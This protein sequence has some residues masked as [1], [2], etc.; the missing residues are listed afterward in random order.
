VR[1]GALAGELLQELGREHRRALPQIA[2]VLDVG[3]GRVDVAAVA[4]MHR[5][6][7]GVIPARLSGGNDLVPPPVVVGEDARVEVA[8]GELHRAGQRGEVE[9]VRRAVLTGVPE[10]VG[11]D[12]PA[13]RVGVRDLDRLAVRRRED[14]AGPVGVAAGHVLAGRD[15]R[16]D[17]D[18]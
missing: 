14:V 10:R 8:E 4:R 6:R 18:R 3:E 16:D 13:F 7:P 1:P 17:T 9:D 15:D 12:E 2:R 11:E 5:P